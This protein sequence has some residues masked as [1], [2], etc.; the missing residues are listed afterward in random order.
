MLVLIVGSE[1]IRTA[2]DRWFNA[3]VDEVLSSA[4]QIAGDYYRERQRRV[5]RAGDADRAR[6][7]GARPRVAADVRAVR[8]AHRAGSR[9]SDASRWCEVYRVVLLRGTCE[10]V[11][12]VDVAAPPHAARLRRAP[13]ADGWR[14]APR[15]RRAE[16]RM[17]E[18]VADGGELIR[19]RSRRLRDA[20]RPVTGVVVASDYLSGDLAD[21]IAPHHGGLR[22]LHASCACCSGRWPACICRSSSW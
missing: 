1:L 17:L 22:G 8:D 18:P 16:P 15:G 21:A 13:S 7:R 11:P 2:V 5:E 12:V 14:R 6:A 4:N 20:Q 19:A 10:V 9:A 3:P